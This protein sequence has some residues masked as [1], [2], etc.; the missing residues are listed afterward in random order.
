MQMT[1]TINGQPL[2][3]MADTGASGV[4]LSRADAERLGLLRR[5][6]V[7]DLAVKGDRPAIWNIGARQDLDQR[8]FAGTVFAE[9][10]MHFAPVKR[11][12]DAVERRV[13]AECL[14]DARRRKHDRWMLGHMPLPPLPRS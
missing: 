10:C 5:G 11:D 7:D 6:E 2:K 13:I 8:G 9:K 12:I 4:V 1:L 14:G 3:F